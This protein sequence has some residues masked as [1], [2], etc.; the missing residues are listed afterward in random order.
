MRAGPCAERMAQAEGKGH[1]STAPDLIECAM[2]LSSLSLS[3]Q[4]LLLKSFSSADA[5]EA[6]A[7]ATPTLTRFMG[8][9]PAPSLEAFAPIWQSWLPMMCAG[10][11]GHFAVRVKPGLEFLG[12]VGLHNTGAAEPETGI[13][14]KESRHGHGYGREAVAAVISFAARNLAKRAV[15]YPVVEQNGPS[16]RLAESLGGSIVGTRLLRKAGGVEH[17]EVVYRIPARTDG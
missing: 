1:A 8:W 17:P 3:S 7:A 4:R 15:V 10:T 2:D 9:D 5:L 13:W 6:F 12:M 14:I 11:D 16:R